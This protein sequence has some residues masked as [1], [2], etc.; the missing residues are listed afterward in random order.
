MA[1]DG[2]VFPR[3]LGV[4]AHRGFLAS[5]YLGKGFRLLPQGSLLRLF[6]GWF[7][8]FVNGLFVSGRTGHV[9]FVAVRRGV[10]FCRLE[11]T[12]L[13]GVV[14]GADVAANEKF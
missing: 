2:G 8:P 3:N 1:F 14:V 5:H 13:E 7:P 12:V 11:L 9:G 10:R 4:E 6:G